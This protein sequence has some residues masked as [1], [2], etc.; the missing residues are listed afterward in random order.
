MVVLKGAYDRLI[1][2]LFE[3]PGYVGVHR[4][5]Q[6]A[7]RVG[8]LRQWC[9]ELGQDYRVVSKRLDRHAILFDALNLPAPTPAPTLDYQI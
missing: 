3:A 4:R 5:I 8:S 1:T 7:D 6:I 2:D 9:Q